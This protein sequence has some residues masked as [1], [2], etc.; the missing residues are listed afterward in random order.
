M[1]RSWAFS[2]AFGGASSESEAFRARHEVKL[3]QRK[4]KFKPRI[5]LIHK[6]VHLEQI[7]KQIL[8]RLGPGAS[9]SSTFF[10]LFYFILFYLPH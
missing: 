8:L 4:I 1:K 6:R 5:K 10:I 9:I 7:Q 3:K 2:F